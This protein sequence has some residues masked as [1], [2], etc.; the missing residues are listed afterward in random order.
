MLLGLLVLSFVLFLSSAQ[1]WRP[2]V[3]CKDWWWT[4]F[5]MQVVFFLHPAG[6]IAMGSSCSLVRG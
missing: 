6:C 4:E 3:R 1:L 2:R 5:L